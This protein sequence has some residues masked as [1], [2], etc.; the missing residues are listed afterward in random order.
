MYKRERN[1]LQLEQL[2]NPV[3]FGVW[4]F[5]LVESKNLNSPKKSFFPWLF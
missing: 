2:T 5:F 1:Y 3:S 4:S